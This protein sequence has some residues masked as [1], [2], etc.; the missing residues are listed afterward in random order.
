ML[1]TKTFDPRRQLW[2]IF[3]PLKNVVRQP[4]LCNSGKFY[5]P[6]PS[7]LPTHSQRDFRPLLRDQ[8]AYLLREILSRMYMHIHTHIYNFI[9][10][11][12]TTA[13]VK[14]GLN[15]DGGGGGERGKKTKKPL[16]DFPRVC[17]THSH[18][19][20]HTK[21]ISFR[22]IYLIYTYYGRRRNAREVRVSLCARCV[23]TYIHMLNQYFHMPEVK[24]L[25]HFDTTCM[26]VRGRGGKSERI[27][28]NRRRYRSCTGASENTRRQVIGFRIRRAWVVFLNVKNVFV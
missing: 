10:T 22:R 5:I 20:A 12:A 8:T 4:V 1:K 21:H 18:A 15:W 14:T 6:L 11:C 27:F 24:G 7:P 26:Y 16:C 25:R 23:Y 9:Y 19:R 2:G 17:R 13:D 3:L 28:E